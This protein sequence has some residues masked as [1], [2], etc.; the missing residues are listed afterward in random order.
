M[1]N[2]E[3]LTTLGTQETG[4]RQTKHKDTTQK[5]TK[6]EQHGPHLN[7][8]EGLAVSASYKTPVLCFII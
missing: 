7:T 3:T 2:S 8:H 4:R 1:D 5:T 6:D